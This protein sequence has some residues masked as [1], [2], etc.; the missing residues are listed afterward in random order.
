ML[1]IHHAAHTPA[2]FFHFAP[3]LI[4]PLI[5]TRR[6]KKSFSVFPTTYC[7]LKLPILKKPNM[8]LVLVMIY[9]LTDWRYC[10]F[11]FKQGCAVCSCDIAPAP[12]Q[13]YHCPRYTSQDITSRYFIFIS[14]LIVK[15]WLLYFS[16][17]LIWA[18]GNIAQTYFY[19]KTCS[20]RLGL[21]W[22]SFGY[23]RVCNSCNPL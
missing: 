9:W 14:I 18:G 19:A 15:E 10:W 21:D 3:A 11:C 1:L 13:N 8:L 12:Y 6:R 17:C 2:A 4:T 22:T 5:P 16:L 7:L 23:K 20:A